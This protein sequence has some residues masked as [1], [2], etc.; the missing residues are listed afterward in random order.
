MTVRLILDIDRILAEVIEK[1][2]ISFWCKIGG[3]MAH[4]T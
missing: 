1:N 4:Y 2:L 3:K